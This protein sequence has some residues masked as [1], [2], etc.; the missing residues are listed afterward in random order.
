MKP[1]DA[2]IVVGAELY[3]AAGDQWRVVP[4]TRA[5]VVDPGPYRIVRRRQGAFYLVSYVRDDAGTAILVDLDE[6]R[7]VHRTAVPA[8][9]LRGL[10][11]DTLAKT[12]RT[13]A[14]VKAQRARI[15][16]LAA[17]PGP[18]SIDAVLGLAAADEGLDDDTFTTLAQAVDDRLE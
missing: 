17:A 10:W 3:H 15:A 7:G 12:G 5:V 13:V 1:T 18:I 16:E 9:E 6:S 4:P 8:R 11:R 2:R 14:G